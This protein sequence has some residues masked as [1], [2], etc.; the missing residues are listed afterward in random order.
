MGHDDGSRHQLGRLIGRVA[1][2]HP[3]VAGAK[4]HWLRPL[5]SLQRRVHATGDIR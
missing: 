2:H 1:E 5:A 4:L 3:L